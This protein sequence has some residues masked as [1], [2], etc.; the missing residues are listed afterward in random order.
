M[1][2]AHAPRLTT[3][4]SLAVTRGTVIF[5]AAAL[6]AWLHFIDAAA[7]HPQVNASFPEHA[8][9]LLLALLVVPFAVLVYSAANR[10]GQGLLALSLGFLALIPGATIHLAGVIKNDE[11]VRS[12]YTGLAMAL[13]GLALGVLGAVQLTR[14]IPRK[15][16]RPLMI[17]AALLSLLVFILPIALA[18][19]VTHVPRYVIEPQDLGAPY[20]E[21]SFETSDGLTLRGWYVPSKNG[22]AVAV[23]HGS[24]GSRNR[25]VEH[26]RMLIRNGYGVLVFDVRGHGESDGGGQALGWG[27]HPDAAAAAAFLESRDDVEPGR[28]GLLGL[29]M[30]A[31]I[32]VTAAAEDD[33]YAAIVAD[34]PSGRTFADARDSDVPTVNKFLEYGGS[35]VAEYAVA[36]LS[37]T[38]PP[39]A[40]TSLSARIEEPVLYIAS[41]EV[42]FERTLVTKIA[43]RSGGPSELWVID[44]AGHTEGLKNFPQAYEQRVI[45][46]FDRLLLETTP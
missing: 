22:A 31:E 2:I 18:V 41:G 32:A 39:P 28:I 29:S 17:P 43:E 1:L 5:A 3:S 38:M 23:V 10:L 26:V 15:R 25:P 16:Y 27:A 46:F 19:Y 33:S 9:Q 7:V 44:G 35:F 21:V 40:L 20:E 11:F 13:A 4:K 36:A 14:A 45:K 42:G 6:L 30:G 34:G 37:T 8:M 24:G 12:D